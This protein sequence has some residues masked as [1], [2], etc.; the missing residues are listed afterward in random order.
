VADDEQA[1]QEDR[2]EAASQKRLQEAFEKGNLPIGRD[3]NAVAG[4][5]A[6]TVALVMVG[7]ALRDSLIRLVTTAARGLEAGASV[8]P[9]ALIPLLEKPLLIA[10]FACVAA[11]AAGSIAYIAQTRGHVWLNLALPDL[12]RVFSGGKMKKLFSKKTALDLTISLVKVLTVGWACWS[13]LRADFLTLPRLLY[14]RP[15]VQFAMFFTPLARGAVRVLTVMAFW[16]GVDIAVQRMRYRK[17]MKMT[18]EEA[19]REYKEEDGDP[20]MKGRRRKKHRELAKGRA[21]REVPRADALIVNPT[22]IAIAIRYR[23]GEA[24]APR[25]TA[26]GKG[27]LAEYMRELARENGIPIVENVALA[28]LLYRRVK[29]G[30]AVPADTY[31][32]I[33]AILAY[34]YRVTGHMA[35][36]NPGAGPVAAAAA[37]KE[38]N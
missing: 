38:S 12:S 14:A 22:H 25:V 27:Q 2:T 16:A 17:Q 18:K 37:T 5:V 21:V 30:R 1:A 11:A 29:I 26:K 36:A 9:T 6:G 13:S 4:F 32:A 20:L 3:F 8:R 33:A 34:V 19:K 15:D 10:G 23:A 7:G 24:A 28:R 31:K 35:N